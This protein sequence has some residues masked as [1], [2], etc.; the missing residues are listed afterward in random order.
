[1]TYLD[2]ARD[3]Y[4]MMAADQTLEA[5]EKYYHD[6][7][8][9]TEADGTRR[10]GKDAQRAAIHEWMEGVDEMHGGSTDWVT[11]NEQEA[12]TMVQSTTDVTWRGERMMMRE[13]A[14]QEWQDDRIIREE[15]FYFVPADVQ[16]KMGAA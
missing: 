2:R 7:V 10:H 11:S 6:D 16:K 4:A 15:F 5:F 3:L 13:V 1:M 8:A 9:I 14:V 12:V